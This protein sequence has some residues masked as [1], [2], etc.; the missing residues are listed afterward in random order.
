MEPGAHM[1]PEFVQRYESKGEKLTL[2]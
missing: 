2:K 1:D